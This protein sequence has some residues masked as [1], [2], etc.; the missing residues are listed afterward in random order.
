MTVHYFVAKPRAQEK[1]DPQSEFER[2]LRTV[3]LRAYAESEEEKGDPVIDRRRPKS[4]LV[5][6]ASN[7]TSIW[8]G[9]FQIA[10]QRMMNREDDRSAHANCEP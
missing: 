3:P 1:V 7:V 6:A 2:L 8:G 10:W 4:R 5:T 9:A